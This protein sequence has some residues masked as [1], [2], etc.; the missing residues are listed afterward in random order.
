MLHTID[1]Y[2]QRQPGVIAAGLLD[3]PQG[4]VLVDPGPASALEGLERGLASHGRSLAD[5]EAVLLT[6]IHLDHAGAA[7]VLA[8]R[9]P[10]LRV[11]VHERGAPHVV[12]PSKLLASASRLYG[13]RMD[14]LWGEMPPVEASRV[15]G[16]RGGERLSPA[17][18]SI[19]VAYTPGHA[20][21]HVSYLDGATGTAFVGDVAGIRVPPAAEVIPPTPPPDIDVERWEASLG[22]VGAWRASRLFLTHFGAFE[23]VPAHLERAR[24]QLARMS[25]FVRESLEDPTAGDAE[26]VDRFRARMH[27][28]LLQG[29]GSEEA[30]ARFEM[31]VSLEHCWQG[32]ARYWRRRQGDR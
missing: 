26:R 11:Y 27:G 13:E 21:H 23:D 17:G 32:L 16:L 20:W 8:R 12:D 4:A 1:L 3:G 28:V 14:A 24:E 19:E 31:A 25:R 22:A 30:A 29:L 9:N 6:H 15:H 10:R 2:F 7:G 5:V 18:R